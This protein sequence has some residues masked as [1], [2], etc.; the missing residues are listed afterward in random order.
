[1]RPQQPDRNQPGA[2]SAPDATRGEP[3]TTRR[4]ALAGL[5]AACTLPLGASRAAAEFFFEGLG[6]SGAAPQGRRGTDHDTGN[7]KSTIEK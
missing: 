7:A 5:A 2:E 4:L 6:P 1:M 3:R